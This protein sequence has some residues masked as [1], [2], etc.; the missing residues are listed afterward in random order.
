MNRHSVEDGRRR[1]VVRAMF[2]EVSK[3][4]KLVD[5]LENAMETNSVLIHRVHLAREI[6][7]L[8]SEERGTGERTLR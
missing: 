3:S 6:L 2:R 8:L 5:H 1:T 7:C 4:V